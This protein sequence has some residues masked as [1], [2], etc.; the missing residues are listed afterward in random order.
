M[1]PIKYTKFV[2]ILILS[3]STSIKLTISNQQIQN[4]TTSV[5]NNQKQKVQFKDSDGEIYEI[6]NDCI[7]NCSGNGKCFDSDCYCE[8]NFSGND[9]S[10]SIQ[11]AKNNGIL[12]E[13][14]Y[15]YIIGV[16]IISF[17]ISLLIMVYFKKPK[18]NKK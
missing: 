2:F 7:N 15:F 13:K 14:Y 10:I 4:Q 17:I 6:T 8:N 11:D 5:S 16:Y 3:L 12:V 1:S 18:K 9:C